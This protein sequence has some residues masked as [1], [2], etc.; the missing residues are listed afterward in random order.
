MVTGA[1]AAKA[2]PGAGDS[3]RDEGATESPGIMRFTVR[4]TAAVAL[5]IAFLIPEAMRRG[6][7]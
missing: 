1:P 6:S 2:L 5:P 7:D 3:M 4:L